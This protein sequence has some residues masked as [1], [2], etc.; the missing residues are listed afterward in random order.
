M[1]ITGYH[2]VRYFSLSVTVNHDNNHGNNQYK[3]WS[4]TQLKI[5]RFSVISIKWLHRSHANRAWIHC[6]LVKS[7]L[8]TGEAHSK[9]EIG[10]K[11]QCN[12]IHF[13]VRLLLGFRK[14][15]KPYELYNRYH[16]E[17]HAP[18]CDRGHGQERLVRRCPLKWAPLKTRRRRIDG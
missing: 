16:Q 8:R 11:I 5:R 4:T 15:P 18:H 2:T 10:D 12:N 17:F 14:T 6:T 7:A 1:V 9:F 13:K 3:S